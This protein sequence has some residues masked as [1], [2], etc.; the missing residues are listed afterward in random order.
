MLEWWSAELLDK[1]DFAKGDLPQVRGGTLNWSAFRSVPGEG[2]VEVTLDPE[3]PIDWLADRIRLTHHL[4]DRER[5][6]GTWLISAPERH[7]KGPVTHVTIKLADKVELLN[8]PLGQ[9]YTVPAA[10]VVTDRVDDIIAA[11]AGESPSITPSEATLTTALTWKPDD[12]W[13]Q[14]VNDLLRA[15][16]YAAL[17]ADLTGRLRV[18]PYVAPGDRS[19]VATY[20]FHGEQF[21]MRDDWTDELPVW[22]LPTGFAVSTEGDETTAGMAARADLPAAH[23]LSA[24]SRGR[25]VLKVE[26]AEATSLEVLQ[27]IAQRRLDEQ[28]S[29][30]YRATI[31]HPVDDTELNDA[32]MHDPAGF[33]GVIVN[34]EVRVQDIGAIVS[35]SVRHIWTD[36]E[37]LPWL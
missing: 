33:R 6:F 18:E 14:V 2:S 12:T 4:G 5:A 32:V 26:E 15:A 7:H 22:D 36:M 16:N 8:S 20:G 29:V 9:W 10:T 19:V 11:R 30:V 25:E 31:T 17:W 1:R 21:Y 23:P 13:L 27:G 28:M 35:D 37:T 24:A 34:R 3:L